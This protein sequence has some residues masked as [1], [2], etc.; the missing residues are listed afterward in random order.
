MEQADPIFAFPEPNQGVRADQR[1]IAFLDLDGTLLDPHGKIS[2]RTRAALEDLQKRGVLIVLASGRPPRMVRPLQRELGIAGPA[3]CY[4]GA[5]ISATPEGGVLWER[6]MTKETAVKVLAFLRRHGIKDILCEKGDTLSGEL[7]DAMLAKA[8]REN[9]GFSQ[10]LQL[11]LSLA[12]GAHKILAAVTPARQAA[13]AGEIRAHLTGQV[14]TVTSMTGD[15]WLEILSTGAGKANAAAEISRITGIDMARTLAFGDGEN[16]AELLAKVGLG[17]AMA[18]GD[19]R[20]VAA[21]KMTAP[22]NNEDGL[23][24]VIEGLLRAG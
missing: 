24:Q 22:P 6:P 3:I 21:A 23:A 9:W 10:D 2:G 8:R 4:N 1:N 12:M 15:V 7:S 16:D 5:L 18:N 19:P 13:L 17:V 20:A 11:P 14:A